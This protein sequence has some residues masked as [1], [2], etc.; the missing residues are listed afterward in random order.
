MQKI[1]ILTVLT[2]CLTLL[3]CRGD[4]PDYVSGNDSVILYSQVGAEDRIQAPW[5]PSALFV[6]A[7]GDIVYADAATRS[8]RLFEQKSKTARSLVELSA[9]EH[10]M[11][12]ALSFSAAWAYYLEEIAA[13]IVIL[14]TPHRRP[15]MIDLRTQG[16]YFMGAEPAHKGQKPSDGLALAMLDFSELCGMG[17]VEG[18][19][20]FAFPD[21]IYKTELPDEGLHAFQAQKLIKLAG[22][23]DG[24]RFNHGNANHYK[25]DFAAWTSIIEWDGGILFG[26]YNA[27]T[28]LKAGKILRFLGDGVNV[29]SNIAFEEF[30][31]R[32]IPLNINLVRIGNSV[33]LPYGGMRISL[34]ELTIEVLNAETGIGRGLVEEHVLFSQ[35]Q[36]IAVQD[37]N[38]IVLSDSTVGRLA[39]WSRSTNEVHT[40]YG[41]EHSDERK[42][43]GDENANN[44]YRLN[45]LLGPQSVVVLYGG[46]LLLVHEPLLSRVSQL[47][48]SN[49]SWHVS[50]IWKLSDG[51]ALSL[52]VSDF[53]QLFYAV[54]HSTLYRLY[55]GDG[56]EASV[57]QMRLFLKAND[58]MGV[59]NMASIIKFPEKEEYKI[60]RT[61]NAFLLHFS[62]KLRSIVWSLDDNMV[63]IENDPQYGFCI[64]QSATNST[65]LS[66]SLDMRAV[67]SIEGHGDLRAAIVGDAADHS[68]ILIGNVAQTELSFLG[69]TLSSRR[70]VI[71]AGGGDAKIDAAT[72]L[73]ES[74]IAE[75]TRLFLSDN[76]L[77]A[78]V[79]NDL[80]HYTFWRATKEDLWQPT[81]EPCSKAPAGKV[82]S[83]AVLKIEE[84][85]LH[86]AQVGQEL[87]AC[88][89]HTVFVAD[90]AVS[91]TWIN[92][93]T[94]ISA[95]DAV[96]LTSS[97]LNL[98]SANAALAVQKSE[99]MTLYPI[100]KSPNMSQQISTMPPDKSVALNLIYDK[101]YAAFSSN[102]EMF[103]WKIGE[104]EAN[105][106]MG[107]GNALPK[108]TSLD[109]FVPGKK[110]KAIA[111]DEERNLYLLMQ[112]SSAL[113]RID[114]DENFDLSPQAHVQLLALDPAIN[115]EELQ[116]A[117]SKKK[118]IALVGSGKV[119][120]LKAEFN[121]LAKQLAMSD[122][123]FAKT[124]S[125]T[126][127]GEKLVVWS[128]AGL[129]KIDEKHRIT[130]IYDA[131]AFEASGVVFKLAA[132]YIVHPNMVSAANGRAVLIPSF[133]KNAILQI[134]VP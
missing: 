108:Q 13:D 37:H 90:I 63:T 44:P 18:A 99:K 1:L 57:K 73:R 67:D 97:A 39:R 122:E 112:D 68:L 59:P 21:A 114:A 131:Q 28:Y 111:L 95:W 119:Y 2:S 14:A 8:I 7:N 76:A 134:A 128:D 50:P 93:N 45:A 94:Q 89:S 47:L 80:G 33:F 101:L 38:S 52:M 96:E 113:W 110:P 27:I 98:P 54:E 83:F 3:S 102:N 130:T 24:E 82:E 86:I 121:D 133:W 107:S 36:A 58:Y 118:K 62:N 105:Y 87:Y 79:P 32:Y 100:S 61:K 132:K 88:S 91:S 42:E 34:L 41:P 115:N 70:Y 123:R 6:R 117:V 74:K 103:L 71:L 127:V 9:Y 29:G 81:R 60:H 26:E 92:I 30:S 35:V 109:K 66:T 84:E 16:V 22:N 75:N 40:L 51:S 69:K 72:P 10:E 43:I 12:E 65:C 125:A 48:Q 19:L 53:E 64:P 106:V 11:G 46:I 56:D 120:Y 5:K 104:S 55:F 78:A 4:Y 129:F 77:Y 17:F 49:D 85:E 124:R 15:A 23:V 25:F 20:Y 31:G 126:F 116:L